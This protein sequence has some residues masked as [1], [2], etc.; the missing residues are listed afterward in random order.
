MLKKKR[1]KKKM[2][3]TEVKIF[4]GSTYLLQVILHSAISLKC[5]F[6][7]RKGVV[8]QSGGVSTLVPAQQHLACDC[9][10]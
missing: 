3:K 8:E 5:L 2:V 6:I 1:R 10:V 9:G 7:Y 4:T